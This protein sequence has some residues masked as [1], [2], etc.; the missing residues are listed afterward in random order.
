MYCSQSCTRRPSCD[1]ARRKGFFR[2]SGVVWEGIRSA[3]VRLQ[4][5][6]S[7]RL[8]HKDRSMELFGL[9]RD[10]KYCYC[11]WLSVVNRKLLNFFI[12]GD[13]EETGISSFAGSLDGSLIGGA[14]RL[15]GLKNDDPLQVE[16][17]GG[18]FAR[19]LVR[20]DF[21]LVRIYRERDE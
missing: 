8:R 20:L 6:M 18:Y 17:N 1:D 11:T 14:F 5:M 19:C 7:D 13:G 21:L 3:V 15:G 16:G 10:S 12:A 2:E 4:E 9:T